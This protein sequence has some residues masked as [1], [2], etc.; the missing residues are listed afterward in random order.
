MSEMNQLDIKLVESVVK[1]ITDVSY[2]NIA[3]NAFQS[4]DFTKLVVN[5]KII[6]KIEHIFS[7]Q[8]TDDVEVI[9]QESSGLCW[10]CGGMT[11]CRRAIIKSLHLDKDFHLS[12]N[13]LLFWD[14]L[15]RCNYFINYIINNRNC[16]FDSNKIIRHI[17]H[18]VSDGGHWHVFVNLVNK[19]GIIPDSIFRRRTSSKNT[20][21]MNSLI[22]YKLR[23]FAARILSPNK[24]ENE[25]CKSDDEIAVLRYDIFT[26][27]VK[28][29]VYVLG[30]PFYPDTSFE[31]TYTTK[32]NKKKIIKNLTSIEFY[33]KYCHIN[34][35][36]F[37]IIMNDPRPR[38]SY[39]KL[40]EM[41]INRSNGYRYF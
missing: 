29:L 33:N 27:I 39:D 1:D 19:Y 38:N 15:E 2:S 8:I 10:M 21:S 11:M 28:I 17:S 6:D 23:E 16:K 22:K 25:L 12:L 9:D 3:S 41:R 18:P 5:H 32:K 26:T 35:N 37:V 31:W 40:Y 14:K 24:P 4:I 7:H 30:S 20:K 34:F 13:H 36:D